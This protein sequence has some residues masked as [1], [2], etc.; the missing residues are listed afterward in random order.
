MFKIV[1]AVYMLMLTMVET[2]RIAISHQSE[3]NRNYIY[4]MYKTPQPNV[5]AVEE[6][7]SVSCLNQGTSNC[8]L[9]C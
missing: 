5:V 3:P 4:C 8:S 9:M 7:F 6:V 2:I 1:G